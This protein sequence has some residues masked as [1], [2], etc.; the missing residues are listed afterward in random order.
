[1]I[2]RR[3]LPALGFSAFLCTGTAHAAVTFS[4]EFT[5]NA[6]NDL[7]TTEQ[8]YFTDGLSFWDDVITGYRDGVN[9]TWTL[10]VDTFSQASSGGGV[11][12]GSAGPSSLAYSGVVADANTSNGRFIL[13]TAGNA[14]FNVHE[15]AGP[16]NPLTI[17]H[18]IGHALGIGT[19]W[20]DNQV[21]NDGDETTG[22]RTLTGGTPGE[23]LGTAAL[24]A[25]QSEFDPTAT[26]IPVE[27]DG[28]SGTADGH[29][30]E[31]TDNF[32]DENSAGYDSDPGDGS[33]ALIVLSGSNSGESLD[34][35]LM[36]GVLSGSGFLSETT[37]ASLYDIGYLV[38][39]EPASTLLIG[40]SLIMLASRRRR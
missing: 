12:L 18:E 23:Y 7:S 27:L 15:D 26:F 24:A 36:T 13:S 2:V 14:S 1:M 29:W 39:P 4:V 19:L 33:A 17:R 38:V 32:A 31:V 21:Y 40:S 10:T 25:Y 11:V 8:S 3:F 28:G 37:I 20:E 9:R 22:N 30:N 34:D 35:E 6:L 5:A 16:L